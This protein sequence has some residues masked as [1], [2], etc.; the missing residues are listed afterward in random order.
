MWRD[1]ERIVLENDFCI[2]L[3]SQNCVELHGEQKVQT[4]ADPLFSDILQVQVLAF[5]HPSATLRRRRPS[6]TTS[7]TTDF[8]HHPASA[9]MMNHVWR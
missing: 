4:T 8:K 6:V 1:D 9:G 2:I 5:S 7:Q 3:K